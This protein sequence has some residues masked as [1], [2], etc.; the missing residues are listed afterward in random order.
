MALPLAP[1]LLA[2]LWPL[3]RGLNPGWSTL[4]RYHDG[5]VMRA[6]I[7]PDER[8]RI[9]MPLETID[10]MLVRA[11]LAVEDKYFYY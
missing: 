10:P 5:S 8:W 2:W 6:Y 4:V 3:P 11:T 7:A 1:L 9:W